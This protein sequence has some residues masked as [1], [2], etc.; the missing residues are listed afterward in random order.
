MHWCVEL[1]Q[2]QCSRS[3]KED[4][5]TVKSSVIVLH[6]DTIIMYLWSFSIV[7]SIEKDDLFTI[8]TTKNE[9][10]VTVD[11]NMRRA[12][13]VHQSVR[14]ETVNKKKETLLWW[15]WSELLAQFIS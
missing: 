10:I 12:W 7:V 3:I 15:Y 1:T 4:S 14:L 5:V 6:F 9:K 13:E 11:W 8:M 2:R